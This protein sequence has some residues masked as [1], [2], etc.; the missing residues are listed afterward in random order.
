MNTDITKLNDKINTL[1]TGGASVDDILQALMASLDGVEKSRQ[2]AEAEKQKNERDNKVDGIEEA[3]WKH[4]EDGRMDWEDIGYLAVL[5]A[6]S[7]HPEWTASHIDEFVKG[8]QETTKHLTDMVGKNPAE[9]VKKLT[10]ELMGDLKN[11]TK[12]RPMPTFPTILDFKAN[13]RLTPSVMTDQD[14]IQAFLN[15][16]KQ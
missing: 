1:M 4:V 10:E 14:K 6:E 9:V 2:K 15:S 16:L 5:V 11:L 8:V 3:F 13:P 12:S 7:E